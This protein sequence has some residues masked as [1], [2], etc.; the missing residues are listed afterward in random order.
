[1][2]EQEIKSS[3]DY[4]AL[5]AVTKQCAA[6]LNRPGGVDEISSMRQKQMRLE[7]RIMSDC[8]INYMQL[9]VMVISEAY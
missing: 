9:S 8:G 3:A 7:S 6:R 1:M 4:R 5:I 2:T